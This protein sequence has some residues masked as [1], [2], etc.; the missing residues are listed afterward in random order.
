MLVGANGGRG[1]EKESRIIGGVN[2]TA[3]EFPSLVT[4]NYATALAL[5]GAVILDE[6]WVVTAAHCGPKEGDDLETVKNLFVRGAVYYRFGHWEQE[7]SR[8]VS[9]VFFHPNYK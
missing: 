8:G 7:V 6:W 4:V 5:C 1:G 9:D 2:T 3:H